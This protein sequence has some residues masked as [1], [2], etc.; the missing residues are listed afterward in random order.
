MV[1]TVTKATRTHTS[2]PV[3]SSD[4]LQRME[5]QREGRTECI[6]ISKYE[7]VTPRASYGFSPSLLA[8]GTLVSTLRVL[9][10]CARN[11]SAFVALSADRP[12]CTSELAALLSDSN[13]GRVWWLGTLWKKEAFDEMKCFY[14]RDLIK[15]FGLT[16]LLPHYF[17]ILN[18]AWNLNVNLSFKKKPTMSVLSTIFYME[19]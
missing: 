17:Y 7:V 1:E 8:G 16:R 3:V 19:K 10:A 14:V 5:E 2:C 11:Q 6:H 9:Q 4:R 12:T 13:Q 15:W 18:G